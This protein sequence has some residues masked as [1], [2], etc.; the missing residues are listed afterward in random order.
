MDPFKNVIFLVNSMTKKS[1]CTCVYVCE[2]GTT[3]HVAKGKLSE[4]DF[5]VG[6]LKR[7]M[8]GIPRFAKHSHMIID[9]YIKYFHN[10]ELTRKL[11]Q[12]F[13]ELLDKVEPV[14]HYPPKPKFFNK[15]NVQSFEELDNVGMFSVEALMVYTELLMIQEKTNYPPMTFNRRLFN[16]FLVKPIY[17]VINT[18][19][20]VGK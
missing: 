5:R 1:D 6:F 10:E 4:W 13:L 3:I 9:L 11:K 18:A 17:S 12:Y 15:E 19:T 8:K 16:D 7:G 20:H 14:S 2:D